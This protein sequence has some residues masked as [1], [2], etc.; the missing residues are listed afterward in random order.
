MD[1]P[2]RFT[3]RDADWPAEGSS[4][5]LLAAWPYKPLRIHTEVSGLS[6]DLPDEDRQTFL[7]GKLLQTATDYFASSLKVQRFTGNMK[8][9]KTCG[10]FS[11]GYCANYGD[12]TCGPSTVPN[13]L[14]G[15][16]NV[17]PDGTAAS[18]G[19]SKG[20]SGVDADY[21][22][23]VTAKATTHCT[24]GGGGTIAYASVCFTSGNNDRPVAGYVNFCPSH[25][26][27]VPE[28]WNAQ[29]STAIHE[30]THALGFTAALFA[31]FRNPDGTP[32]TARDANGKPPQQ[33]VSGS[34]ACSAVSWWVPSNSTVATSTMRGTTVHRFVT[35]TVLAKARDYFGCDS[36]AG[37]ELEN[38]PTSTCAVMG[39]HW[40][41]RLFMSE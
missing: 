36:L 2:L 16:A 19:V 6:A 31:W 29:E 34:G 27:T 8:L 10:S 32:R 3:Q 26:Q 4:V 41:L 25:I 1:E 30:L 18:C 7:K 24:G 20:G 12:T 17:C 14:L 23:F 11:G 40:E 22:L 28:S 9:P 39:S 33:K 38:S 21:I 15:D 37:V 5:S 35:P 13:M